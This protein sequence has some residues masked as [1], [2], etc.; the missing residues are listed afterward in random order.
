MKEHLAL[1]HTRL[2][3]PNES[4][5]FKDKHGDN[6]KINQ[7]DASEVVMQR[8]TEIINLAKKQINLLTKKQISYIILTGGV[9]E[10]QDF[11]ILA[12]ELLGLNGI[13]GKVN[14]IGARN[15]KYSTAVGMLKYY[16]SRLKLR[17]IDF[18]I[19][20]LEEQEELSGQNKKVNIPENSILG[21]LFGYFFD[22]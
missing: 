14:E 8:L 4:L 6:I 16:N 2:A 17:N 15:N 21:K 11:D 20:N 22:N 18:S 9:T 13:I 3:Q 5:T 10:T 1:A 19:F 12:E 7:Y